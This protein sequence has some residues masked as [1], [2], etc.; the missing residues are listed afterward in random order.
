APSIR[1]SVAVDDTTADLDLY[2][3]DCTAEPKPQ[4]YQRENGGKAPAA[5]PVNC[6]PRA[7]ASGRE[8]G[9]EVELNDPAPGRWVVVVDAYMV[10]KGPAHYNYIDVFTHSRFG[11]I[12]VADLSDD[13]SAGA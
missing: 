1:A 11:G 3:L 2:L 8:A 5:P 4:S 12:M 7:K 13:R 9:G 10:P 6:S